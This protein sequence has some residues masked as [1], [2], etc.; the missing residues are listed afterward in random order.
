MAARKFKQAALLA[1]MA[2]TLAACVAGLPGSSPTATD[3]ALPISAEA[4]DTAPAPSALT[5]VARDVEAPDVFNV[6][7]QGLWDGR[8]SLGGVWVA[9]KNVKDPERVMIR[10]PSNG[11]SVIGALFRREADNPGPSLQV[12]SDAAEALGMLAGQ[13]AKLSVVALKREEPKAP[14]TDAT[15]AAP[16]KATDDA[17]KDVTAADSKQLATDGKA[18]T[19]SVDAVVAGAASALD[20][21]EGKTA[22]AVDG[23]GDATAGADMAA[24]AKKAH[25]WQFKRKAAEAKA[26]DAQADAVAATDGTA[27]P[28]GTLTGGA[29]TAAPLDKQT[30]AKQAAAK[31]TAAKSAAPGEPQLLRAYV[32]IGI[33]STE[34]NAKRAASQMKGAG[35]AASVRKDDSNGKSFWRVIVGPATSV[36]DR[37]ALAARVKSVGYPDAYPVK[38]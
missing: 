12:S 31:P 13:P 9:T 17:V 32:Q 25:W 4:G 11:K 6:S 27:I 20:K 14:V 19:T 1:G 35:L 24:P 2:G 37:D 15:L 22:A 34:A 26:G 29:V 30:G 10:N 18:S 33:F 8:P 28:A 38:Q 21:A 3:E 16:A 5:L 23:A 7:D 36:A